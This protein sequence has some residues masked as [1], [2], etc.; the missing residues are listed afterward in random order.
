[1]PA[2]PLRFPY[3][4]E[5]LLPVIGLEAEFRVFVDDQEVVPE[6]YWRA[7]SEFITRPLLRRSSIMVCLRFSVL[8][9]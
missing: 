6:E 1:M 3:R 2:D 5:L 7:P 8:M 9:R 4:D